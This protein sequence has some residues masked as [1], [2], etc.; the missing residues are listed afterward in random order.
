MSPQ[1]SQPDHALGQLPLTH[2]EATA[3]PE[4]SAAFICACMRALVVG[5]V[6]PDARPAQARR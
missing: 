1:P 6:G 3:A 2:D 4:R 5:P